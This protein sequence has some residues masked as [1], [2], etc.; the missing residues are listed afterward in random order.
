MFCLRHTSVI[1]FSGITW[2]AIGLCLFPLGIHF[3]LDASRDPNG[4]HW[5]LSQFGALAGGL[6]QGALVLMALCLGVGFVKGRFVLTKSANRIVNRLKTLPDP[7]PVQKAYS[8][9]YAILLGSMMGLGML[10]R[11]CPIDIRGIVDVTIGAALITGSMAYF[12]L[13]KR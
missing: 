5:V 2:L 11:L 6:E 3:L 8:P 10:M 9:A 13:L 1:V 12:R 7:V 4:Q